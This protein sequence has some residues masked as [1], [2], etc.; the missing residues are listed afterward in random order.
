M[1]RGE[2]FR[3]R[4]NWA[5]SGCQRENG[6]ARRTGL[7]DV[8]GRSTGWGFLDFGISVMTNEKFAKSRQINGFGRLA[9]KEVEQTGG[10]AKGWRVGADRSKIGKMQTAAPA[11]S[12][13]QQCRGLRSDLRQL[14][15]LMCLLFFIGAT[16]SFFVARRKPEDGHTSGVLVSSG[17]N[18]KPL[19]A[20]LYS[21][22]C[23]VFLRRR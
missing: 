10:D 14:V 18:G 13:A 7:I 8:Q 15:V 9:G 17:M 6:Q 11:F 16:C 1:G 3:E 23:R 19:S 21:T 20:G 4:L 5:A 2:D 12:D 22:T